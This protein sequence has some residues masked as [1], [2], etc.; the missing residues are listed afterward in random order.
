LYSYGSYNK[1]NDTEQWIR[2]T[3]GCPHHHP[4]C[5]EP[6][7]IKVFGIPEIV[8]NNIKMMDMNLLCKPQAL[9]IIREL[10]NKKVNDKVVYYEL[11]CG[12]DYR[13][14]TQEIAQALKDS[15]FQNIRLAWDWW[16]KNQYAI[17]KAI[18]LLLKVGYKNKELMVFMICNWKIPYQEN[19]KKLDLCKVWNIKVS[20]CWFDNQTSPNIKSIHWLPEEIKDFRRKVRKHNQLVTFG[21]DPEITQSEE[22]Q[23]Q[24]LI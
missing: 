7:E 14:L 21:I 13:F 12:I 6:Q 15:R 3:E 19:L 8:R 2:I 20:D 5:Y 1:F 11:I 24:F 17:N 16:Y 23:E 18:K 22:A 4:Y 9:S 10:G